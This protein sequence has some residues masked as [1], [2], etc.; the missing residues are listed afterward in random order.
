MPL[1]P[2]IALNV[3]PLQLADPLAQYGQIAQLQSAQ[4]QNALAQFQLSSAQRSDEQQ[5]R[6]YAAAQQ[7]NFKLNLSLQFN[8]AR[9]ALQLLKRK[10]KRLLLG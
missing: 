3:K 1:D 8:M 5:N 4:N 9:L 2:S 7:P 6:L 10:K